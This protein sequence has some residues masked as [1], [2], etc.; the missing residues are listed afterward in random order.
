MCYGVRARAHRPSRQFDL[1]QAKEKENKSNTNIEMDYPE[2]Y[3]TMEHKAPPANEQTNNNSDDD[4]K[5]VFERFN[6]CVCVPYRFHVSQKYNVL[7]TCLN[8]RCFLVVER[9]QKASAFAVSATHLSIGSIYPSY[10][11][12]DVLGSSVCCFYCAVLL[13]SMR[14]WL[15]FMHSSSIINESKTNTLMQAGRQAHQRSYGVCL[16]HRQ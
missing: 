3:H 2:S 8:K 4:D 9:R 5:I 7:Y 1:S 16:Y 10:I 12:A 13:S 15:R 11:F 14:T 6:R